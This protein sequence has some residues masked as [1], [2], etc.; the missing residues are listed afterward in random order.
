MCIMSLILTS[1]TK[2]SSLNIFL[3]KKVSVHLGT[4]YCFLHGEHSGHAL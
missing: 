4:K 2:K 1:E 3:R